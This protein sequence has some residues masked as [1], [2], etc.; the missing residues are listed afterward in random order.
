MRL[1]GKESELRQEKPIALLAEQI[2]VKRASVD[3]S[4]LRRY[5]RTNQSAGVG[6]LMNPEK[7][8]TLVTEK[9]RDLNETLITYKGN[10]NY[11]KEPVEKIN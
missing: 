2:Q 4:N 10:S 1:G 3:Y 5:Q 8:E 6:V 9:G 11:G 7:Q